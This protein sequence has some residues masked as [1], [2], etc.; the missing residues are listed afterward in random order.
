MV[1]HGRVLPR[2]RHRWCCSVSSTDWKQWI[3]WTHGQTTQH[4]L[5]GSLYKVGSAVEKATRSKPRGWRKVKVTVEL[6]KICI[7]F[8]GNRLC[9]TKKK[10]LVQSNWKRKGIHLVWVAERKVINERPWWTLE[11]NKEEMAGHLPRYY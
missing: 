5:A 9:L 2:K 3:P 6:H 11:N 7:F 4:G 8:S 1:W 10:G